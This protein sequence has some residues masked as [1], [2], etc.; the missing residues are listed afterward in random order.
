MPVM[1]VLFWCQSVQR[2]ERGDT[3]ARR[4]TDFELFDQYSLRLRDFAP[5]VS[6]LKADKCCAPFQ[7]FI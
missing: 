2:R 7:N 5:S 1:G 3:E 6:D 4:K